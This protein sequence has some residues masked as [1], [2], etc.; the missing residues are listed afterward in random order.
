M[1]DWK[2]MTCVLTLQQWCMCLCL[3]VCVRVY[4]RERELE[5]NKYM[6]G[7]WKGPYGRAYS[8]IPNQTFFWNWTV[9][10]HPF[11]FF[12]KFLPQ[13]LKSLSSRHI[14]WCVTE[15]CELIPC[16]PGSLCPS[17][18][19]AAFWPAM[20]TS[21]Q[22]GSRHRKT[23]SEF[24]LSKFSITGQSPLLCWNALHPR[25]WPHLLLSRASPQSSSS[26]QDPSTGSRGGSVPFDWLSG[27]D[28]TPSNSSHTNADWG[29][30]KL[31]AAAA[32]V[33]VMP[34]IRMALC[35]F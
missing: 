35:Y 33:A 19:H 4:E 2:P 31:L 1:H 32:I 11:I 13:W 7:W 6:S 5:P 17:F 10:R 14:Y 27:W 26:G 23:L 9:L 18:H 29:P 21:R 16:Y 25:L 8:L 24:T 22:H 34:C 20:W 28:V 12:T 15:C 30:Q 3:C